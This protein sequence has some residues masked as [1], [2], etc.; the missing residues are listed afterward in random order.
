MPEVTKIEIKQF[1]ENINNQIINAIFPNFLYYPFI[2]L[3]LKAQ[4]IDKK[5]LP[6]AKRIYIS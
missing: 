4:Y 6:R 1:S 2:Y 5:S 3:F